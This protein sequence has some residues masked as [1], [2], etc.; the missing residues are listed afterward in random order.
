MLTINGRRL[1]HGYKLAFK[2]HKWM[3]SHENA[4]WSILGFVRKL[5]VSGSKGRLH[6]RVAIFCIDNG[7]RTDTREYK[8]SNDVWTG[9]ERYLVIAD[10]SLKYNPVQ[11]KSSDID[12]YG[13]FPVSYLSSEVEC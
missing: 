10:P 7:I 5:K 11:A 2:T 12:L 4:F 1:D 8:F 6:D 3:E 13:L 9:L